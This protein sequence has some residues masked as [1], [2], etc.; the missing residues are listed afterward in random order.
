MTTNDILIQLV[1]NDNK[2]HFANKHKI[3]LTSLNKWLSQDRNIKIS[4]L[5]QIA[6]KEGYKLTINL[7]LEKL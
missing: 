5:E 4:T 1:G 2:T 7:K 3:P 6:K